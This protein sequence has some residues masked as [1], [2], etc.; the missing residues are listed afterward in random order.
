MI[1]KK[2]GQS[3]SRERPRGSVNTVIK[4]LPFK[5]DIPPRVGGVL[6]TIDQLIRMMIHL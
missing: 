2:L 4:P 5:I 6:I 3:G 1:P